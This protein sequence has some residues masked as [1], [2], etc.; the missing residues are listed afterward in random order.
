MEHNISWD[1]NNSLLANEEPFHLLY[2]HYRVHNIGQG[3][4][5]WTLTRVF[6]TLGQLNDR[7]IIG[8][9]TRIVISVENA[10]SRRHTHR[11][12]LSD[13]Q[14]VG[15]QIHIVRAPPGKRPYRLYCDL[16]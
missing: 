3:L 10:V 9:R 15:S 5:G 2:T 12:C 16:Q 13:I 7:N 4:T 11:A 6:H 1:G 14:A 8:D